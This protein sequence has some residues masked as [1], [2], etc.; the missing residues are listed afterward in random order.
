MKNPSNE[1]GIPINVRFEYLNKDEEL[2]LSDR[3]TVKLIVDNNKFE[4]IE[5]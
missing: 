4:D 5:E 3:Y 1:E 2:V